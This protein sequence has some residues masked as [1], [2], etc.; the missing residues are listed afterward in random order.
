MWLGAYISWN[1]ADRPNQPCRGYQ[2]HF[3]CVFGVGDLPLLLT[4]KEHFA[5]KLDLNYE[6]AALECLEAWIRQKTFCPQ[7]IDREYYANLP[8]VKKNT[9]LTSWGCFSCCYSCN[10]NENLITYSHLSTF[11]FEDQLY[12][13][14]RN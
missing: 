14:C 7:P 12:A 3:H 4:R 1:G 13:V 11:Q 10:I 8:F 5:N 2:E 6:P 9:L